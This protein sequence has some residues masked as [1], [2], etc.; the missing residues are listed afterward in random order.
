MAIR[1]SVFFIQL[2]DLF[3]DEAPLKL[4]VLRG[5]VVKYKTTFFNKSA[6]KWSLTL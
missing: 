4:W 1:C 5:G 6:F 2:L 3:P